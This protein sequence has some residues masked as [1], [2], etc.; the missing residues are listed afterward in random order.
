MNR[1]EEEEPHAKGDHAIN[2][3]KEQI[4]RE[5]PIGYCADEAPGVKH[6]D[7]HVIEEE[8]LMAGDDDV[9]DD[10]EDPQERPYRGEDAK[11]ELCPGEDELRAMELVRLLE[12]LVVALEELHGLAPPVVL[13]AELRAAL[14]VAAALL[15]GL[16]DL[17]ELHGLAPDLLLPLLELLLRD[18]PGP[19]R[20]VLDQPERQRH[21]PDPAKDDHEQ[22]PHDVDHR[23]QEQQQAHAHPHVPLVRAAALPKAA[24]SRRSVPGS[25]DPAGELLGRDLGHAKED[26]E[27]GVDGDEDEKDDHIH[28]DGA[29]QALGERVL[30]VLNLLGLVVER[31]EREDDHGENPDQSVEHYPDGPHGKPC[32]GRPAVG[33]VQRKK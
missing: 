11:G 33:N 28:D 3:A 22:V 6:G 27:D 16:A 29:A 17:V 1:E 26:V 20:P 2:N 24:D 23:H 9:E 31:A 25:E 15:D 7:E 5:Y 10:V 18:A 21:E 13:V 8:D 30:L 12:V 32:R 4:E 19:L 14:A